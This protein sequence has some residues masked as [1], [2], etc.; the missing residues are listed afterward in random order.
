MKSTV[1]CLFYHHLQIFVKFHFVDYT[2]LGTTTESVQTLFICLSSVV[3]RLSSVVCRL[4]V[5][6]RLLTRRTFFLA[7]FLWWNMA[8]VFFHTQTSSNPSGLHMDQ[9]VRANSPSTRPTRVAKRCGGIKIT[10]SELFVV[11]VFQPV[12]VCVTTDWIEA[13]IDAIWIKKWW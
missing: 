13:L 10:E 9:L 12:V 6:K 11:T 4:S 5:C 8:N 1:R 7:R 3:C 2:Q